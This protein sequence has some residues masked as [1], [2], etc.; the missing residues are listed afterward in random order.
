MVAGC[1]TLHRHQT[2]NMIEVQEGAATKISNLYT[3]Y[4]YALIGKE[5]FLSKNRRK[6]PKACPPDF[7]EEIHGVTIVIFTT[8]P[9]HHRF[10]ATK[11][12]TNFDAQ[13][14]DPS[15]IP[16]QFGIYIRK[17]REGQHFS[18]GRRVSVMPV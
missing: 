6:N 1:Q 17:H 2:F 3:K 13:I 11:V 16:H 7:V 9:R 14:P 10:V 5:N 4:I 12:F 18:L 15:D 8:S